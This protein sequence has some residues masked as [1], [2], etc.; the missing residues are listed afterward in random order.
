MAIF[1]LRGVSYL[2]TWTAKVSGYH[3]PEVILNEEERMEL[4]KS[5]KL[6]LIPSF[7]P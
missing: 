5:R 6:E 4:N 2:R 1:W 3:E 7:Y